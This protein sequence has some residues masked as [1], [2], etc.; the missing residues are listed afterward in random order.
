ML[1]S[2]QTLFHDFKLCMLIVKIYS[3]FNCYIYMLFFQI[4]YDPLGDVYVGNLSNCVLPV[5]SS[6]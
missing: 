3:P 6:N 4:L 2:S 5:L 1:T